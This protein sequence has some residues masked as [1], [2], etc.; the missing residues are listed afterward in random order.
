MHRRITGKLVIATHNPGKLAEMKE[1]LAPYGIEAVSAGELDLPEPEETGNDF[2]SNAAIKAIAAAQATKLPSFADDSGIVVDAL[3]GAPGIYSAR[4]AGPNKDFAAAMAQIERLLQERG[5]TT[6]A[7]RK[8]H[9]V[10]ALCVAWPDD[11]LEE[12]EGRVDGTLVWPPRGTAGF[13]YDPMFLPDGHS[14]TFGEMESI[15]KHGLP[16]LGLGLSHRARAFVKLA[17]ICLEP[18]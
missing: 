18:R 4:W 13:G 16:P 11:H 14:R 15:E 9:F 8:A 7:K 1:L 6:P 12:V 10:S 17:E 3:D 5:A 2:R